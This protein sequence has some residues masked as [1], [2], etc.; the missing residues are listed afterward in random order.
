MAVL[1]AFYP[2]WEA[3]LMFGVAFSVGMKG[4]TD[5]SSTSGHSCPYQGL[6]VINLAP[7]ESVFSTDVSH[8]LFSLLANPMEELST[9]EAA[10]LAFALPVKGETAKPSPVPAEQLLLLIA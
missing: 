8:V 6:G 7:E 4:E 10:C 2:C 9:W 3:I 5:G 1:H